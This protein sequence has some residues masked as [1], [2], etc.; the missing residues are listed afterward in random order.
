LVSFASPSATV[1]GLEW[2]NQQAKIETPKGGAM[3]CNCYVKDLPAAER[4]GIRYG[5]HQTDCPVYR[6]SLDPVDRKHDE[7][8]RQQAKDGRVHSG[9]CPWC[10]QDCPDAEKP[11]GCW[12]PGC[13]D[14]PHGEG[15]VQ[16]AKASR[17]QTF[18]VMD[19]MERTLTYGVA[20]WQVWL[21]GDVLPDALKYETSSR[22]KAKAVCEY[23]TLAA[24]QAHVDQFRTPD[25]KGTFV[26]RSI[27]A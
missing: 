8:I 21:K 2:P 4:F 17:P 1:D 6:E 12:Y 7:A 22:A 5:A 15:I 19:S 24:E 25:I 11:Q 18:F 10:G 26:P 9:G 27:N 14:F 13:P 20:V 23:L 3:E 16:Q